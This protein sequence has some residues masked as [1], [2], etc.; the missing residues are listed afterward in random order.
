MPGRIWGRRISEKKFFLEKITKWNLSIRI[1]IKGKNN[2]D[3]ERNRKMSNISDYSKK[4]KKQDFPKN[5][6]QARP[7]KQHF[8]AKMNKNNSFYASL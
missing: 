2:W 7:Q 4:I 8:S 3:Y 1:I 5:R 6:N